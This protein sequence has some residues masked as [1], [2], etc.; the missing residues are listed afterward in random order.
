MKRY[1]V[2]VKTDCEYSRNAVNLLTKKQIPFI[3]VVVDKDPEF[4]QKEK[5]RLSWPTVP[6]I[7]DTTDEKEILIGGFSELEE[8]LKDVS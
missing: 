1:R 2:I 8:I 4:L 6:I 7:I 5:E 3:C